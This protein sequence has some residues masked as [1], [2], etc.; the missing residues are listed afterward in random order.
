MIGRKRNPDA[1]ILRAL[2]AFAPELAELLPQPE[3]HE[4]CDLEPCRE[5][6]ER[7]YCQLEAEREHR[8]ELGREDM[9]RDQ[10]RSRELDDLDGTN[11][12]EL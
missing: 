9:R 2:D 7:D 5:C 3:T 12:G 10:A 4:H 6:R 1:G 11:R 8:E